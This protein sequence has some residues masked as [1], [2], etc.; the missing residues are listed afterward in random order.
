MAMDGRIEGVQLGED[1]FVVGKLLGE[2][3]QLLID[4]S[5]P[6][7]YAVCH[8]SMKAP[9]CY[10]IEGLEE[11]EEEK[12]GRCKEERSREEEVSG[13]KML[14]SFITNSYIGIITGL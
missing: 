3:R 14:F 6:C 8:V 4:H 7:H 13:Q 10:R 5:C 1:R 2:C 9:I 11:R 12:E